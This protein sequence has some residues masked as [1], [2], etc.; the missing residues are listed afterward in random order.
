MRE[1]SMFYFLQLEKERKAES[2]I[3]AK[4][5]IQSPRNFVLSLY[6]AIGTWIPVFTG[7]TEKAWCLQFRERKQPNLIPVPKL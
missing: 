1:E 3:P 6:R 4:A 7:M 2:V 5:G